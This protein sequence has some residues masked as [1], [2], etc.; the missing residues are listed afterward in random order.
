MA[1]EYAGHRP[2]QGILY[3]AINVFVA[4]KILINKFFKKKSHDVHKYTILQPTDSDYPPK[5]SKY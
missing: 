2:Y 3:N 1:I 4:H 5:G